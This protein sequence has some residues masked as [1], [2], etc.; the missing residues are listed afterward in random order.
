MLKKIECSLFRFLPYKCVLILWHDRAVGVGANIFCTFE[1]GLWNIFACSR[2]GD[3][4]VPIMEYFTP[5]SPSTI[6]VYN[7][8]IHHVHIVMKMSECVYNYDNGMFMV[9]EWCQALPVHNWHPWHGQDCWVFQ[10]SSVSELFLGP[11]I[12]QMSDLL[13]EPLFAVS[14]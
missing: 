8:L 6:I 9:A 4:N 13:Y 11:V 7:S 5:P 14:M 10:G 12:Q 1:G 2:G 3:E